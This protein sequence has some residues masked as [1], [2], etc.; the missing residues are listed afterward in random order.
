MAITKSIQKRKKKVFSVFAIIGLSIFLTGSLFAQDMP[1]KIGFKDMEYSALNRSSCVDCHGDELVATHHETKQAAAGDCTAC[2]SV[3]KTPGKVG[4]ALERNC[5]ICHTK[6]PH[7]R[8]EAATSNECGTCHDSAG[9]SDYSAEVPPYKVSKLTPTVAD[10]K[11]CHKEGTVEGQKVVGMKQTHHGIALKGCN[12]C[13]DENDKQNTSIR[14]CE[15]C[16]S[17]RAIHEVLPH[18]E[19]DACAKCH[20]GKGAAQQ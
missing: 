8:T 20:S 1:Q 2:H 12:T 3:S 9:L 10:C 4:V 11:T 17:A 15:R 7:H 5:M 19:K 13:H 16:H 6:S 18:V 14:V